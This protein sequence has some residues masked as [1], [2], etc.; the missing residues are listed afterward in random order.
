MGLIQDLLIKKGVDENLVKGFGFFFNIALYTLMFY[1]I[2][3]FG[4][5][6]NEKVAK[7]INQINSNCKVFCN[8]NS[9]TSEEFISLNRSGIN[10]TWL[11]ETGV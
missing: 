4:F 2:I 7:P 6:Y 10:I 3:T 9:F 5:M 11:N 8:H 1:A